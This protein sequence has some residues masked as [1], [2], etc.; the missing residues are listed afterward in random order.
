MSLRPT[1]NRVLLE[2][3]PVPAITKGGIHMP[4]TWQQPSGTAFVLAVGAKCEHVKP[5]DVVYY[6]WINAQDIGHNGKT[7]RLIPE[8]LLTA[9]QGSDEDFSVTETLKESDCQ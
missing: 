5:G 7:Y 4:D 3:V 6:S 2:P 9:K 8:P 1:G